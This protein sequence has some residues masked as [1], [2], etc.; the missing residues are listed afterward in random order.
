MGPLESGLQLF[1][2]QSERR[3]ANGAPGS[4]LFCA[5]ASA[6]SAT[7]FRMRTHATP[8]TATRP[9]GRNCV[10][11]VVAGPNGMCWLIPDHSGGFFKF[12]DH[13]RLDQP[14]AYDREPPHA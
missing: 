12:L 4:L 5:P 13:F 9:N 3:D 1:P 10:R 8:D 6:E 2:V 7:M 11:L 14:W